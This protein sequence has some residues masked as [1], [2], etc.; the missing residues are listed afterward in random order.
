MDSIISNNA[1]EKA[2][3]N[4]MFLSLVIFCARICLFS[5]SMATQSQINSEP[6][7]SMVSSTMY[8]DT[9]F[10]LIDDILWGQY[11][12]IH[13][14]IATWLI[15]TRWRHDNALTTFLNDKPRK[16]KYRPY[17]MYSE[18]VLFLL[19]NISEIE[20]LQAKSFS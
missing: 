20:Y 13:F 9:F 5:G 1:W 14:H 2:L 10:L 16:Y 18:D 12:W 3:G 8:S 7:F 19:F 11:F 6:T 15:L 4:S 17:S